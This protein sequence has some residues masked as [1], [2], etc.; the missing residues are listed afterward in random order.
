M[1]SVSGTNWQELC[2]IAVKCGFSLF[3]GSK[4]T[5]VKD[6][7]GNKIT[8]ILRHSKIK[9]YTAVGIIKDLKEAGCQRKEIGHIN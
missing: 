6:K 3:E 5:I 7:N 1:I 2:R 8:T 4:H 9:K